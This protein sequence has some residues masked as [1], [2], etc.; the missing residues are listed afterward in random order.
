MDVN[1]R[2]DLYCRFQKVVTD[3]LPIFWINTVPFHTVYN[4]GLANLPVSIWGV[5]SPLDEL[6]WKTP[7]KKGYVSEGCADYAARIRK[8]LPLEIRE[9]PSGGK[10]AESQK[11]LAR[12]RKSGGFVL[13]RRGKK[14]DSRGL[15]EL[16]EKK[17]LAG[18]KEVC[19]CIGGA[20]GFTPEVCEAADACI[21]FSDLTFP[22]ELFRLVFLEQVYRALTIRA[23]EKYHRD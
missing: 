1:K 18:R 23:G 10:D 17:A 13:D 14:I 5:L 11:V 8:Y 16:L 2:K 20:D 9:I 22:H 6:Y 15:S 19:F 21:S 3:E 7:L 12:M 4:I